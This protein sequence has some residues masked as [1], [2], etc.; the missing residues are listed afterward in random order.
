[1]TRIFV[2]NLPHSATES[3]L[4]YLFEPFGR[5]SNI[6][7]KTDCATNRP[8]GFAFVS[9][10]SMEDADEAIVRLSGKQMKGRPLTINESRGHSA[11]AAEPYNGS[12]SPEQTARRSALDFFDQLRAAT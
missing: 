12:D 1:M 3:D 7:I 9:M 8:R 4:Y 5:V 6:T 11:S 2:G 10:P